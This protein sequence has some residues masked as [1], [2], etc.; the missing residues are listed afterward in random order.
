MKSRVLG[1]WA[2]MA[3]KA[4]KRQKPNLIWGTVDSSGWPNNFWEQMDKADA[5]IERKRKDQLMEK[6]ANGSTDPIE[7]AHKA[8]EALPWLR[9]KKALVGNAHRLTPN[10]V[11]TESGK[12]ISGAEHERRE[13]KKLDAELFETNQSIDTVLCSPAMLLVGKQREF[14]S[15]LKESQEVSDIVAGQIRLQLRILRLTPEKRCQF[16]NALAQSGIVEKFN[17]IDALDKKVLEAHPDPTRRDA[18]LAGAKAFQLHSD[19]SCQF[20]EKDQFGDDVRRLPAAFVAQ[21]KAENRVLN[22]HAKKTAFRDRSEEGYG[23]LREANGNKSAAARA[24]G[25][26]RAKVRR[27]TGEQM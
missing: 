16:W 1:Q 4:K 18:A 27:L 5:E 3:A 22:S 2:G 8:A 9:M 13:A 7:A 20:T 6:K 17:E 11:T 23:A 10:K 25:V 24:L 15:A 19:N 21:K 12:T 14:I 26:S